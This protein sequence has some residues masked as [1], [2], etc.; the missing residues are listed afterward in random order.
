MSSSREPGE[1]IALDSHFLSFVC[2]SSQFTSLV[3]LPVVRVITLPTVSHSLI[4]LKQRQSVFSHRE[5]ERTGWP[6]MSPTLASSLSEYTASAMYCRS[7][8]LPRW[9]VLLVVPRLHR[10]LRQGLLTADEAV[11][12]GAEREREG[13]REKS[14]ACALLEEQKER[15]IKVLPEEGNSLVVLALLVGMPGRIGPSERKK[16]AGQSTLSLW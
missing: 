8:L 14:A 10:L 16:R 9:A 4:T 15:R 11:A 2:I 12:A 7:L 1:R 6:A 13:E 5:T 3:R